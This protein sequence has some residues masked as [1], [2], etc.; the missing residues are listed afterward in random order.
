MSGLLTIRMLPTPCL[1]LRSTQIR[2]SPLAQ[3]KEPS[4]DLCPC[5]F[6]I[7][8]DPSRILSIVQNGMQIDEGLRRDETGDHV[9][10]RE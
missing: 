5:R 8:T 10:F 6:R 4:P 3:A 1:I 7:G 2:L 9:E